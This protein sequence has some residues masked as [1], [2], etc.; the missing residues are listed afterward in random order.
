MKEKVINYLVNVQKMTSK[1]AERIY[2]QLAAHPDILSEFES[3][4]AENSFS[5]PNGEAIC[6]EGWT[7]ERLMETGKLSPVG[8]YNYLVYLREEPREAIDMLEVG[9]PNK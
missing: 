8:A 5:M 1:N 4:I 2:S 9:L 7:A 3:G 6:V